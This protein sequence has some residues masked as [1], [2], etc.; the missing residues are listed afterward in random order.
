M[1]GDSV[2]IS[3]PNYK[4]GYRIVSLAKDEETRDVLINENLACIFTEK[5][6]ATFYPEG[7]TVSLDAETAKKLSSCCNYDVFEISDVGVAYLY[8]NNASEDNA[9]IVTNK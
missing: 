4:D 8:Y 3:L 5:N 7:F 2:I 6:M 9:L 1:G